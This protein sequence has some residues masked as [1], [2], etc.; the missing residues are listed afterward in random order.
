MI[1]KFSFR[2]NSAGQIV[3]QC[4]GGSPATGQHTKKDLCHDTREDMIS[5]GLSVKYGT[6]IVEM[7]DIFNITTRSKIHSQYHSTE[8]IWSKFI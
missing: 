2:E 6:S 7:K 8:R 3:I 4:S 5:S 1:G